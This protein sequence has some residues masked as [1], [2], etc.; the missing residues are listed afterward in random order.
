[1]TKLE[2]LALLYIFAQVS[3]LRINQESTPKSWP[4]WRTGD[5]VPLFVFPG[6]GGNK[7]WVDLIEKNLKSLNSTLGS[8]DCVVYQYKTAEFDRER[9]KPCR[10][11]DNHVDEGHLWTFWMKNVSQSDLES[12]SHLALLLED[13]DI[14]GVDVENLLRIM[15]YHSAT[16]V[17]PALDEPA[18][19]QS[20]LYHHPSMQPTN[21]E[22]GRIVR[23]IDPQFTVFTL[24][25]YK[26]WQ[27]MFDLA[28]N[29]IGW[30]YGRLVNSVCDAKM[31][32]LDCVGIGHHMGTKSSYD[33][34]QAKNQEQ[35]IINKY[36]KLGYKA[37]NTYSQSETLV[38]LLEAAK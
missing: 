34:S 26:C 18:K 13:V 28:I 14:S 4:D 21:A 22:V 5:K 3:S 30:G 7:K 17:S 27:N 24:E 20:G 19:T 29:P 35:A 37:V 9:L 10:I 25:A 15:A 6:F 16:I 1:M 11:V 12:H 32:V 36:K 33:S 2:A 23:Y 31:A 38:G 8:F